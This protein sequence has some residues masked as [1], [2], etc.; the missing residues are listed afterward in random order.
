MF[1]VDSVPAILA[2]SRDPFVV[3]SSNAFAILGLRALYFM[4]AGAQDKLVYL[5]RGLGIILAYVGVKMIASQWYHIDAFISLA[6]IGVIL[7]VTVVLSLRAVKRLPHPDPV[8]PDRVDRGGG[9]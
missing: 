6:I 8:S 5:N 4:L 7:A 9:V 1:A 2:V 3:F